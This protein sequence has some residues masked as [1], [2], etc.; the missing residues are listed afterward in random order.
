LLARRVTDSHERK[1]A[2]ELQALRD[3]LTKLGFNRKPET[4]VSPAVAVSNDFRTVRPMRSVAASREDHP[5]RATRLS[6]VQRLAQAVKDFRRWLLA[7]GMPVKTEQPTPTEAQKQA[8][9]VEPTE[10]AKQ[11]EK[12]AEKISPMASRTPQVRPNIKLN[13]PPPRRSRGIGH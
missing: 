3:D 2:I 13:V 7:P 1:A 5:Q 8:A 9:K 12:Q 11:A 4:H 10:S 6:P